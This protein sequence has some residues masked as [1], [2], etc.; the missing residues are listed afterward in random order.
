MLNIV[1]IASDFIRDSGVDSLPIGMDELTQYAAKSGYDLIPYSAARQMLDAF[2]I[3]DYKDKH[4]LTFRTAD[5]HVIFYDDGLPYSDKL[6]AIAHEIGH[7]VL[8]HAYTGTTACNRYDTARELEADAF[9]RQ[10]LAPLCVLK[11]CHVGNVRDVERLT[12]LTGPRAEQIF[13][14][15]QSR[16]DTIGDADD[17]ITSLYADAISRYQ[18]RKRRRLAGV[19]ASVF[20]VMML[21]IGICGNIYYDRQQADDAAR[22]QIVY[23]ASG[24]DKYH[25]AG[26]QYI[27]GKDNL[28]ALTAGE[29]IGKGYEP[30]KVCFSKK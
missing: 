13:G 19:V 9:A 28:T 10:L 15:Y 18:S 11:R 23:I 20:V 1:K 30:C 27:A 17:A 29:A 7:I 3:T 16:R 24:G 8:R 22:A 2:A 6:F 5:T 14:W 25:L 4:A 26:C 12:L 21:V